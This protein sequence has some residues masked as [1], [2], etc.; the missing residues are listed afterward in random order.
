MPSHRFFSSGSTIEGEEF[1]HLTRVMR[2]QVGD[3]IELIDGKGSLSLAKI[4]SIEKKEAT[5]KILAT[6]TEEPPKERY[7]LIQGVPQGAKIEWVL[8]KGT[9]L[10]IDDFLFFGSKDF[11]PNKLTR[12]HHILIAA[13]KQ[14]GRLFLPTLS[15]YSS[16][17][18]VPLHEGACYGDP[19]GTPY[20][21]GHQIVIGPESGFSEEEISLL[22]G[23]G[24]QGVSLGKHILRTETAAIIGVYT[25]TKSRV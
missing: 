6:S 20:H 25:M 5:L 14:C 1:H 23:K 13:I 24:A 17:E 7:S 15:F 16:L 3:E 21:T 22:K 2:N 18:E 8:E 9:E 19:Q 11:S 10:D 12:F 4:T